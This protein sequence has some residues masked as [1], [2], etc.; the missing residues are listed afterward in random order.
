M[1]RRLGQRHLKA[2]KRIPIA[3][4]YA[5]SAAGIPSHTTNYFA[6]ANGMVGH[7]TALPVVNSIYSQYS[8]KSQHQHPALPFNVNCLN[9][10]SNERPIVDSFLEAQYLYHIHKQPFYFEDTKHK[11]SAQLITFFSDYYN[12]LIRLRDFVSIHSGHEYFDL[13]RDKLIRL[14]DEFKETTK[15]R[16]INRMCDTLIEM[17]SESYHKQ[18]IEISQSIE[19]TNRILSL[20]EH[21]LD[22]FVDLVK[23]YYTITNKFENILTLGELATYLSREVESI[24]FASEFNQDFFESA[25]LKYRLLKLIEILN[26]H[27]DTSTEILTKIINHPHLEHY[28]YILDVQSSSDHYSV[29]FSNRY[30]L[31]MLLSTGLISNCD[32]YYNAAPQLFQLTQDSK[33]PE[34]IRTAALNV[35]EEW[36]SFIAS[37]RNVQFDSN[38]LARVYNVSSDSHS[39]YIFSS[40]LLNQ[41]PLEDYI[42]NSSGSFEERLISA[43]QL[44]C[45]HHPAIRHELFE[46]LTAEQFRDIFNVSVMVRYFKLRNVPL[47]KLIAKDS[48]VFKYRDSLQGLQNKIGRKFGDLNASEFDEL[49]SELNPGLATSLKEGFIRDNLFIL[50][51]LIARGI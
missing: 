33:Q 1:I 21:K 46:Y 40:L 23:L 45:D 12:E 17:L 15:S 16:K 7:E 24:F 26:E 36:T 6:A 32:D 2:L 9:H 39:N 13:P 34:I 38:P 44:V 49:M 31:N 29:G 19:E 48:K 11:Y 28:I 8:S 20:F 18:L 14:I 41:I 22:Y 43:F 5:I 30:Y 27:H 25:I 51:D 47:Y 42:H 10:Q 50:D 4:Y 3:R 35:L 37:N